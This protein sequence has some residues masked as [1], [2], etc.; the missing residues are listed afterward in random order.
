MS[1]NRNIHFSTSLAEPSIYDDYFD[2]WIVHSASCI[3][4]V[5][6]GQAYMSNGALKKQHSL[7]IPYQSACLVT[8]TNAVPKCVPN[9]KVCILLAVRVEVVS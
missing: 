3:Y 1:Y 6:V 9:S 4:L 7:I 5:I 8:S 2:V